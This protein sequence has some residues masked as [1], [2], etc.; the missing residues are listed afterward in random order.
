M[1]TSHFL[2]S[3]AWERFQTARDCTTI[4]REGPGWSYLAIVEHSAGLT[5]LYCPYGPTVVSTAALDDALT[6]LKQ[7]AGQHGADYLRVQPVGVVVNTTLAGRHGLRPVT[8]SQPEATR[9]VDLSPSLEDIYAGM[10]QSKRSICRNYHKK[11]LVYRVSHNPAEIELLLPLLHEVAVRNR[12]GVHSDDYLRTQA[13]ALM[14][15]FAS[16]H[17]MELNDLVVA[18]ALVF[19][20]ETTNY[21]AHAGNTFEHRALSASTALV[22]EIL[23]Y[24]KEHGKQSFDFYGVAP[25]DDPDHAWA[26]VTRFKESFGGEL[27]RYNQ[28]YDLPLHPMKYGAYR[29]ARRWFGH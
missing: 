19:D 23:R 3:P 7:D 1:T 6:A 24:S 8:Y 25:N 14:P 29:L 17:F 16:L 2:Q 28:T 12:I 9:V 11:G 27:V 15:E 22:G 10:S 21:Y 20:G 13:A 18:A 4:R 26:G 5:R